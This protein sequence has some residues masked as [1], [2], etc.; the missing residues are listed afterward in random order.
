MSVYGRGVPLAS[1]RKSVKFLFGL[2]FD[3][4]D[5]MDNMES[6]ARCARA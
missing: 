4:L 6:I 5:K 2:E 3:I 1:H